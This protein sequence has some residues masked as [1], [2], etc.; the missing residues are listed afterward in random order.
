LASGDEEAISAAE[1]ALEAAVIAEQAAEKYEQMYTNAFSGRASMTVA[2]LKL[3][4]ETN[5][6]LY[7]SFLTMSDAEWLAASY[8]AY[9]EWL[10]T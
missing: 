10:D 5:E 7:N 4:K 8:E 1:D 6:E 2:D 3:L 9:S